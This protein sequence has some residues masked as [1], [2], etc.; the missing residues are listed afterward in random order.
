MSL[1][2]TR[3]V[4]ANLNSEIKK[5]E[6]RSA[7]GLTVAALRVR[8]ASQQKTPVDEGNL[9]ASA[10]SETFRT[11]K[12]PAAVIGYTAEYAPWVHEMPGTLKG[13]PRPKKP[14]SSADRGKFWDPQSKAEPKFLQKAADE[15]HKEIL[16]DIRKHVLVK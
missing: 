14:G 3:R 5:I 15:N 7:K 4:I 6:N 8:R 10:F 1:K 2:G 16:E 9:R 11:S 12:G 13:K